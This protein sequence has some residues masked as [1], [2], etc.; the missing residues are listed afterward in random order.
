MNQPIIRQA[1]FNDV[2][3]PFRGDKV[4]IFGVGMNQKQAALDQFAIVE[5]AFFFGGH[6]PLESGDD[7]GVI[8]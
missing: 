5:L 7:F 1:A 4:L 2:N 3:M 8:G 6:H